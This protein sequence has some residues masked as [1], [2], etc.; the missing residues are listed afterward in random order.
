M[1]QLWT[2]AKIEKAL[3]SLIV[4]VK[5]RTGRPLTEVSTDSRHLS[6]G[7]VFVALK[8]DKFDGHDYAAAA[9]RNGAELLIV[10]R[11]IGTPVPEIVVTD[12]AEAYGANPAHLRGGQQWQ[13]DDDAD[14]C[15]HSPRGARHR[16][17]ACYRR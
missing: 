13:N 7:A 11:P 5:G 10:E 2:Q 17:D 3:G 4:E 15:L 9:Q 6:R 1:Q 12:T 16:S 14:D 8:G